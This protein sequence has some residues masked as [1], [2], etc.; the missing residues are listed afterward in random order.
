MRRTNDTGSERV[1]VVLGASRGLGAATARALARDGH[2][3]VLSSRRADAL[4]RLAD[5]MA[6]AGTRAMIAP[7]DLSVPGAASSVVE[8]AIKAF[9]RVDV[10]IVNG[11]GPAG[12]GFEDLSLDAWETG[13]RMTVLSAV[14]AINAAIPTMRGH[15]FGRIIVV[16][17]SSIRRPIPNLTLSNVYRPAL[18]GL[19]KSLAVEVA[20]EGVT[21]NMVAPGRIDTD[22][23]AELDR[24]KALRDGATYERIRED[25][26]RS[27]PVGRYGQ[28][29]EVA[30]LIAFLASDSSDYITGQSI[31]VDGALVPTLP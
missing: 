21:V 27:I 17:S 23:V 11:G 3:L 26:E 12:G 18:D 14:E 16:G 19:V 6:A 24:A 25:S 13:F 1:A 9:G 2:G 28:P 30:D 15:G 4:S 22:R 5:E 7:A 10:L 20:G 29:H 8:Q 31:L